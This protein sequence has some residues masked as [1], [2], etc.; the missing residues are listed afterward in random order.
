[1]LCDVTNVVTEFM[2][3]ATPECNLDWLEFS[4]SVWKECTVTTV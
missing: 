3:N 1:V 2:V 4:F